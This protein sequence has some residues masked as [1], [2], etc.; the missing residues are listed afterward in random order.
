MSA[1]QIVSLIAGSIA[2]LGTAGSAILWAGDDRYVQKEEA[3]ALMSE[4]RVEMQK[5]ELEWL[6]TLKQASRLTREQ[7]LKLQWLKRQVKDKQ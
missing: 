1:Q 7:E 4:Q 2:L 5:D 6:E 3:Q